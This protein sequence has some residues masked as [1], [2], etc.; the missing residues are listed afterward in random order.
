M[1]FGLA[2]F[3]A[4]RT[5]MAPTIE[6]LAWPDSQKALGAYQNP[7]IRLRKSCPVAVNE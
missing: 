2:G 5:V 3:P 7:L 4:D 1:I 6:D